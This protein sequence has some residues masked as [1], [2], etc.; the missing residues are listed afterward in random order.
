MSFI[1]EALNKK[2]QQQQ[3]REIPGLDAQHHNVP[4]FRRNR[5]LLPSILLALLVIT[6]LLGTLLYQQTRSNKPSTDNSVPAS[7]GKSTEKNAEQTTGDIATPAAKAV[8]SESKYTV[9]LLDKPTM[10]ETSAEVSALYNASVRGQKQAGLYATRPQS[11]SAKLSE[12]GLN[13]VASGLEDDSEQTSVDE[14]LA[15]ALWDASREGQTGEVPISKYIT[16]GGAQA[17]TIQPEPLDAVS[18]QEDIEAPLEDTLAAFDAV[19]FLHELTENTQTT[20]P[21]LMYSEHQYPNQYVVFNRETL[22]VGES[23]QGVTV[24]SVLADGVVLVYQG[25][26]FKL[27]ALSSWV[28]HP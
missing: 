7:H 28:N 24:E 3:Q 23:A 4:M 22:L 15:K 17:I 18:L 9:T 13:E 2:D 21:T 19:P 20:I 5:S 14:V 12:Q 27:R 11:S 10:Q 8:I 25:Q 26:R 6:A 16:P 1:L